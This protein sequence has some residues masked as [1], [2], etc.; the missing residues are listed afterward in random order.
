MSQGKYVFQ[1]EALFPDGESAY[2]EY[3]FIILPPWYNTIY[4]RMVYFLMGIVCLYFLFKLDERRIIKKRKAEMERREKEMLVKEQELLKEN[5]KKEQQI[6]EL[7]NEKLEQELKHKSQEMAN[8]M[9]HFSRKNEIL[10]AI[11]EELTR[12]GS[13]LKNESNPKP[14]RMLLTLNNKIDLNIESDDALKQFEEQFDLVHNNFIKKLSEKHPT[15]SV[16]ERKMCA[17]IKMNLSSKEVA[18][19]MNLSVRGVETL[20]YRLRKKIGLEREDSLTEYLNN[21]LPE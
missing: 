7:K 6:I 16:S 8:L 3:P 19:L 15:L 21:F 4:A 18:P 12:I 9:I 20:R 2:V 10:M 5:L 1:V 14:K 11:K 17:Y 13:E